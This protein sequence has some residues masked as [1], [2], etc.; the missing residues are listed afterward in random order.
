MSTPEQILRS[1]FG[2]E[3]FRGAQKTVIDRALTGQ[4]SLLVMPTGSGKSLCY[5]IPG[6]ILGKIGG[7]NLEKR[8]LTLVLSPLI[9]LMKDQVDALV[10]KG[11]PATFINSSLGRAE[12][13]QRM[14]AI[15]RGEF[16]FLYVTP[17]RFRKP[18][19]CD[20]LAHRS[21]VLL[22]V[23]EAHCISQW[24]HDFRPDYTRVD[25]IRVRI[26]NPVT[27]ALT[28]TA[29]PEV[30]KDIVRQLGL[31]PNEIEIYNTGIDRPNLK[32][33][34]EDVWS[35]DDKL[36]R[37]KSIRDSLPGRGIVYFTLIRRLM[38]FSD[39]L[40]AEDVPH[41]IYHGELPRQIRRS[42]Q[43]DF[44]SV[45]NA[46]VLATNAFGMGI[47]CPDIRTVTHAELPGS[48]ESYYQEIGRAGRDGLE[49]RCTLLYDQSDLAT[50][51]E[52]VR[53]SNPGVDYYERVFDFIRRNLEQVNAFGLEW[54]R[55]QVESERRPGRQLETALSMLQRW[56]AIEGG[57]EPIQVETVSE[58]PVELTDR[59]LISAKLQRDQRKLL[60]M[61]EYAKHE[62][63][64]KSLL[65][66]YF[67][68]APV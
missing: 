62:G 35:D 67:G 2:H 24:G 20:S 63:D 39:L 51:M 58:L 60:A 26:G 11:I 52:F 56:G 57:I 48:L 61:M 29:T 43:E 19:F 46:F 8:P 10:T 55:E 36:R 54:L 3:Q 7:A 44:M 50:Q 49:S 6:T 12:R 30:Q 42:A 33:T 14:A 31:S 68:E 28:A 45:R 40:I 64:H 59:E 1:V 5:Q 32:L 34:V 9:A 65:A 21:I 53:W 18:D 15:R 66:E 47:D 22:A 25:E 38:E 41:L 23:D 37:I 13:E 4:N 27:V 16:Q 17:E